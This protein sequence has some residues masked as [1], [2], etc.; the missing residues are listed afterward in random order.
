VNK[1][2]GSNPTE[3]IDQAAI[4]LVIE[5]IIAANVF[6]GT[7]GDLVAVAE[8]RLVEHNVTEFELA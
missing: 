7:G 6:G 8:A 1:G 3:P 2:K 5:Q 4:K